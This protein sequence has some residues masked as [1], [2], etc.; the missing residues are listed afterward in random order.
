MLE[1]KTPAQNWEII[2]ARWNGT[3]EIPNSNFDKTP[4]P[5]ILAFEGAVLAACMVTVFVLSKFEKRVLLRFGLL[6]IGV[7]IFELFTAPMWRNLKLG[8]WAY[9]YQQVSWILTIGWSVLILLAVTLVDRH[10]SQHSAGWRF[11]AYLG[12]LTPVVFGFELLL[13]WLEVRHYS[14]EVWATVSGITIG[15]V[16]VEALY[17]VPVFITLII[18]FYK[19]WF[20]LVERI[21]VPPRPNVPWGKTLL[22]SFIGVFLFELMI[23]PMV[24]NNG[25]PDWSYFY[26]DLSILMSGTWVVVMWLAVGLVELTFP[27]WP[28]PRRFGMSLVLVMLMA[29]PLE[30]FFISS[31]MR[32][33]GQSA[34]ANF[35]GLT[36]PWT[37]IPI[38][39][40]FAIPLYFALILSFVRYMDMPDFQLEGNDP[41]ST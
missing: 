5:G 40:I 1:A 41:I 19:F 17:Y 32:E 20:P 2:S 35:S 30:A 39:V 7:L 3:R 12:A 37:P 11:W 8:S 26:R 22:S 36:V 18:S 25:F 23:E 27:H 31:G 15:G 34:Q 10:G 24:R 14:P 13:G 4:T 28:L 38:E 29:T 9:L 6:A 33:Y 16:P 21:P